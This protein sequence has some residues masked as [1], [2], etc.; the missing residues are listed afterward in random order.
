MALNNFGY[1]GKKNWTMVSVW[2]LLIIN[3][4]Y[5]DCCSFI[6]TYLVFFIIC[7]IIT[8]IVILT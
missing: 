4:R 2:W 7:A 1:R 8:L 5:V 6:K 3:G